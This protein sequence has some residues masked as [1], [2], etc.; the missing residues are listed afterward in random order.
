MQV[1]YK[2][3]V[4]YYMSQLAERG[5]FGS[6]AFKWHCLSHQPYA[7]VALLPPIYISIAGARVCLSSQVQLQLPAQSR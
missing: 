6:F 7:L 3:D 4:Q 2:F 5:K 1:L